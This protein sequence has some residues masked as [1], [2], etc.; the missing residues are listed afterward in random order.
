MSLPTITK[1]WTFS[2]NNRETFSTVLDAMQAYAYQLKEF[3]K[4]TMGYTVKGSCTAGTGAMDG[5]DRW[6]SKASVTPRA[7]VAAASQAWFV[8]TDASGIDIAMCFQGAS[9]DIFRFSM[10]VGGNFVAAGTANQQPTATDEA[11]IISASTI[12]LATAS[13]DRIW[14]FMGSSDKK[15]F[16]ATVIRNSTMVS[17]WGVELVSSVTASPTVF[18]PAAVGFFYNSAT[19]AV[20]FG[21]PSPTTTAIARV[22][23]LTTTGLVTANITLAGGGEGFGNIGG[24]S[25][26]SWSVEKPELQGANGELI[27]PLTWCNQVTGTSGKLANRIDWWSAIAN[28]QTTP[29]TGDTFGTSPDP[30]LQFMC[31]N[32][33]LVPW[34]G[35]TTPVI[36]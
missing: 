12:V 32:T 6:A 34:D 19:P 27:V 31:L 15:F 30:T 20:L 28:A 35:S 11:V 9:D 14:N 36:S 3:L 29:A 5:T 18:T 2:L 4:T 21:Q 24:S 7:T 13:L 1:T 33:L 17:H 26:S 8:L 23:T 25:G 10:S 22:T 16:R